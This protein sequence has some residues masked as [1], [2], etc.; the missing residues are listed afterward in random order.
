MKK[1]ILHLNKEFDINYIVVANFA[2]NNFQVYEGLCSLDS[3]LI[4]TVF[5]DI[6]SA[7]VFHE[8]IKETE[9]PCYWKQGTVVCCGYKL[10]ED[11]FLGYAYI[12]NRDAVEFFNFN[13]S[14]LKYIKTLSIKDLIS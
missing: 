11:V 12:E 7:K 1:W 4:D 14:V 5:G 8:R 9:L 10:N 2:E 6:S 13:M 3:K